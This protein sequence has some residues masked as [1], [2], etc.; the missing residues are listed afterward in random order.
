MAKQNLITAAM[1]KSRTEPRYDGLAGKVVDEEIVR[2]SI[3]RIRERG[4]DYTQF[5]KTAQWV[6]N[7]DRHKEKHVAQ[8]L[9]TQLKNVFGKYGDADLEVYL[10]YL[11]QRVPYL[12]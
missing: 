1:R 10:D 9:Y 4:Q 7:S 5:L 6:L 8:K 2:L 11:K 3:S 12:K